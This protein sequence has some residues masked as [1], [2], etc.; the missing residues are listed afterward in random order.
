MD[1]DCFPHHY[2]RLATECLAEIKARTDPNEQVALLEHAHQLMQRGEA[3]SQWRRPPPLAS[4]PE[5]L[6]E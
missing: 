2:R 5:P 3:V 1:R 4:P 6:F